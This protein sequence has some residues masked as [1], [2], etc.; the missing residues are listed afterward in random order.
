MCGLSIATQ[1]ILVGSQIWKREV[2]ERLKL[3]N[4]LT[5]HVVIRSE[6]KYLIGA[7]MVNF[8]C[9]VFGGKAAPFPTVRVFRVVRP[10]ATVRIRVEPDP[11]P[12]RQFGPVANTSPS[13]GQEATSY[14]NWVTSAGLLC[15]TFVKPQIFVQVDTGQW[16][17]FTVPAT[18]TPI[19]YL[20]SDHII[21][22]SIRK[23][24]S[25]SCSSSS[26]F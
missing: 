7:K 22:W 12:T 23:M 18:L 24:C 19:K 6:L 9:R 14:P 21:T 2:K 1:R 13:P 10:V 5:D 4:L 25:I 26:R 3:H 11:E 8:K 16:F 15:R 17:H 20:G